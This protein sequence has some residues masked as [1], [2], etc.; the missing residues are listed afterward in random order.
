MVFVEFVAF[1][2]FTLL[3]GYLLPVGQFYY[4]Y[5]VRKDPRKEQ[6]RIQ[7]RRP[8]NGQVRHEILS[9]LSTI[10]IFAILATALFQ[11]YLAGLTAVYCR[12]SDYPLWY[13]PISFLFC[14][15]IHDTF[16]YW[17]HRVMH[18]PRVFKYVHLGHHRSATPT[19]W[20]IFAFQP[21][22]SILQ[23]VPVALIVIY[24]PLHP[25]TL[26]AYLSYDTVIN[27]A[28]HTGYEMIPESVA[29]SWF[30]RGLNTVCHHDAHHSNTQVN[31]GS[32]FNV[33]DRWMGTFLDAR[34]RDHYAE[35]ISP[36]QISEAPWPGREPRESSEQDL[37]RQKPE[38][39]P[40][41]A[42]GRL[43]GS[44]NVIAR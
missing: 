9:S 22:E 5:H 36:R 40:Q 2:A 43:S 13:V 39:A 34:V 12:L 20:A 35:S 32:F 18:W 4:W 37:N 26:L 27:T 3:F 44:P 30:F 41:A 42:R 15:V 17:T 1:F 28:G 6:Q 38:S 29:S 11:L 31:F 19:P 23:F 8:A 16:F 25:L 7:Q 14:L 24:V 21:L 10:V 33:W